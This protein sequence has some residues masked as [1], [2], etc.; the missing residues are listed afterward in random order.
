MH[1]IHFK[2]RALGLGLL[3]LSFAMSAQAASVRTSVLV[4]DPETIAQAGPTK[5]PLT[6]SV[7]LLAPRLTEA[8]RAKFL[9]YRV[10]HPEKLDSSTPAQA[11]LG[12]NGVPVLDQGQHGA[13][14]TFS[15]TGAVDAL[16]G[17]GD[18]VSQ[19]CHLELGAYLANNGYFPSGW[20]G[21]DGNIVL[22]QMTQFGIV[23]QATQS[24]YGC[25]GVSQYPGSDAQY[26]GQPMSL[27]EHYSKSEDISSTISW[28]MILSNDQRLEL[29]PG[30]TYDGL[31]VLNQVKSVLSS[32][33]V[34]G[35]PNSVRFTFG[36]LLPDAC[37]AGAC[38]TSVAQND[39]WA[40]T[41]E[42]QAST[43]ILGGH[44]MIITG[45]DDNAV[46]T[47]S[48]GNQYTGLLTIRNSWGA[49][50]GNAGDFY[51]TYDFFQ[52][53]INEVQKVW[54]Q[55]PSDSSSVKVKQ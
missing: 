2:K 28:E 38:A 15:N 47:D 8:Q 41:P 21:S 33:L 32:A 13:C 17:K 19:L 39:T 7:Y 18:Y 29:S 24:A 36:V 37:T 45:Y 22:N 12:M 31:A 52:K 11:L 54:V 43:N 4:T 40:I 30:Y 55:A 44:E 34:Q 10:K 3:T 20:D 35:Q 14:V 27:K 53:Y 51:M 50:T 48:A 42:V 26:T 6:K 25:A 46:A 49:E 1:T 16:L 5:K 9:G 23:S